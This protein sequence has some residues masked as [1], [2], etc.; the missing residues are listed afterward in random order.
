MELNFYRD[1]NRREI[2]FIVMKNKKPLFGV[3]CKTGE[4]E[5]ANNL[6]YFS[7]VLP[8]PRYYQVHLGTK[9]SEISEY[10]T[11]IIPLLKFAEL[12]KI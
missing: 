11:E 4:G 2:D 7:K 10:K 3:E 8:I 1:S 12:L 6:K 5:I 9:H